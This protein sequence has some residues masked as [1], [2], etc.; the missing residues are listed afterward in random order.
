MTDLPAPMTPKDC[1]LQDF[2]F[3]PLQVSRLR[4]SDFAA[5]EHPEAC[6]YA[7]LLW[8]A[9]WHQVPAASLPDNEIVLMRIC[10]LGRDTKTW[11]KHCDGALRGFVKCSDGR[12]YH[13]VVA[14]QANASWTQKLQQRW[15]TE[16]ARIRK[17]NERNKTDIPTP[18]YEDFVTA[19]SHDAQKDVTPMSH[20]TLDDVA[21]DKDEASHD[22]RMRH[23]LQGTGRLKGEY[24]NNKPSTTDSARDKNSENQK[25]KSD[26][27]P[28]GN[29]SAPNP[30]FQAFINAA[31]IAHFPNDLGKYI[32]EWERDGISFDSEILPAVREQS[33][34]MRNSG[35]PPR[36][37]SIFDAD[38]RAL[39]TENRRK[40]AAIRAIPEQMAQAEKETQGRLITE[41]K[42]ALRLA[43]E[44]ES[45]PQGHPAKAAPD[46]LENRRKEANSTIQRIEAKRQRK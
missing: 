34:R 19:T 32:A 22:C 13:S 14:E 38:I 6:W 10:G 36:T 21:C 30:K 29:Q 8:A 2:S 25:P 26:H 24:I 18:S 11:K 42:E 28:P 43:D 31:G 23:P 27:Q 15:R 41:A 4:D 17:L 5:E 3:M 33:Q 35:K 9:S 44:N 20:V 12:L 1:D 46:V 40:S 7:V 16:C 39:D 45:L 37:A